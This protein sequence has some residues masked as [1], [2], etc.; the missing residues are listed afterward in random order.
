MRTGSRSVSFRWALTAL[1]GVLFALGL[2]RLGEGSL[3][4]DEAQSVWIARVSLEEGAA[5]LSAGDFHPP[6]YFWLL[7]FWMAL[8]GP[9]EFALRA[10]ALGF[11]V[12]A[13]AVLVRLLADVAPGWVALGLGILFAMQPLLLYYAQETRMYTLALFWCGLFLLTLVRL[14]RKPG[15]HLWIVLGAA[16]LGAFYTHYFAVFPVTAALLIAA[17]AWIR[18]PAR[19]GALALTMAVVALLYLPWLSSLRTQ[20]G[21]SAAVDWRTF[22]GPAEA[23][24]QTLQLLA[25]GTT[26]EGLDGLWIW[27]LTALAASAMAWGCR[28][29]R[30]RKR[31]LEVGLGAGGVLLTLALVEIVSLR[32]PL[33]VGRYLLVALPFWALAV[34][35]G[36]RAVRRPLA[37]AV[38]LVL[39]AGEIAV[40]IPMYGDTA[41]RRDDYRAA[42]VYLEAHWQPGD[43]LLLDNARV[44]PAVEWY[45]SRPFDW[46][47]RIA[48][49]APAKGTRALD[50]YQ[51]G[52]VL[53]DDR[54]RVARTPELSTVGASELAARIGA[55]AARY[56]RLWLLRVYA[57]GTSS[58]DA[59]RA[60]GSVQDERWFPGRSFLQLYSVRTRSSVDRLPADAV[61]LAGTFTGGAQ[62]GGY[63]LP[64]G[65]LAAG[66]PARLR[67]YWLGAALPQEGTREFARMVDAQGRALAQVDLPAF[68]GARPLAG[69]YGIDDLL[70]RVPADLGT[71]AYRIEVGLHP[72]ASPEPLITNS[73]APAVDLG[74]VRVTG[75][76]VA[77]V[78]SL[79]ATLPGGIEL[80][81]NPPP[82]RPAAGTPLTIQLAWRITASVTAEYHVFV[83]A[84]DSAGKLVAQ[85][86]GIP[87]GGNAPTLFWRNGD[88]ILDPHSLTLPTGNLRLTA[89]L[90]DADGRRLAAPDGR[91]E[92]EIG[93]VNEAK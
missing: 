88:T 3:W 76:A 42:V 92:F 53:P 1:P 54:I 39:A 62:L 15:R 6:L 89:G 25:V 31:G 45:A 64:D 85:H 23:L 51:I 17:L 82:S 21:E 46:R 37:I 49:D 9:S 19:L 84:Y 58:L 43:A 35:I 12:L 4:F 61:S 63:A 72:A 29:A 83:H 93:S 8:T 10:L 66:L 36:L 16:A 7:H 50:L 73:G 32:S 14:Q 38:I 24:G 44:Y 68:G 22:V 79:R 75:A 34:G 27:P 65:P 71:G 11:A 28:P 33:F 41:N 60:A 78:G 47:G 13:L 74:R 81:A 86:D 5:R 57:S 77:E 52:T 18:R 56:D 69:A 48:E 91:D 67:L 80:W 59:L 20:L 70:L 90:Y 2:Q 30:G 40:L 26:A 55:L 87:A